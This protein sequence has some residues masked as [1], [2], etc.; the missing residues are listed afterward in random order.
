KGYQLKIGDAGNGTSCQGLNLTNGTSPQTA[1]VSGSGGIK[2]ERSQFK[3]N[4]NGCLFESDS[5]N[6]AFYAIDARTATV[7]DQLLVKNCYFQG[8]SFTTAAAYA[9]S[10]GQA[11]MNVEVDGCYFF[12]FATAAVNN[13]SA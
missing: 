13:V 11:G 12:N 7:C 1:N 8:A 4:I 10:V 6:G 3:L 2:I 9:I 5:A